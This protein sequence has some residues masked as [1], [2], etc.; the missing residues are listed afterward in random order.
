MEVVK[1]YASWK[2]K[3]VI[4]DLLDPHLQVRMFG[5]LVKDD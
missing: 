3:R 1:G 5:E 2:L 4:L